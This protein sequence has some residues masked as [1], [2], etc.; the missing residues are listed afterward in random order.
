MIDRMDATLIILYHQQMLQVAGVICFFIVRGKEDCTFCLDLSS[1]LQLCPQFRKYPSTLLIYQRNWRWLLFFVFKI[2]LDRC[3][4]NQ[5]MSICNCRGSYDQKYNN[6]VA[7]GLLLQRSSTAKEASVA[8]LCYIALKMLQKNLCH[9]H[10][11]PFS[12]CLI[13]RQQ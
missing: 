11:G 1:R 12:S 4:L 2:V 6:I 7:K 10:L 3:D 13:L 5:T 8:S 9:S